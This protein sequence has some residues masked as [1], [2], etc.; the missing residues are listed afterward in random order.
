MES[1]IWKAVKDREHEC[2][3]TSDKDLMQLLL[4]RASID[5]NLG[6]ESS[7]RF[8][9]DNCKGLYFAGHESTAVAASWCLMLLAL[10]PDWQARIRKE[11]AEVCGDNMPDADSITRMKLVHILVALSI[12]VCKCILMIMTPEQAKMT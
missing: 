4:E 8:I 1:L 7:K 5:P 11:I 3:E 12:I 10:H 6:Q 2:L 9:V